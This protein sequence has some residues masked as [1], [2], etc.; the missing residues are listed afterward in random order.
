VASAL[1]ATKS[2]DDLRADAEGQ[3][4]LKRALGAIPD[5]LAKSGWPWRSTW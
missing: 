3:H 2:V 4:G 1:F 5:A